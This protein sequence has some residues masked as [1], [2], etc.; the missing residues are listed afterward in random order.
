MFSWCSLNS[1]AALCCEVKHDDKLT[2]EDGV[3][4]QVGSVRVGIEWP[5]RLQC[6]LLKQRSWP[7]ARCNV[8]EGCPSRVMQII[9]IQQPGPLYLYLLYVKLKSSSDLILASQNRTFNLNIKF[10]ND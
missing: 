9:K 5:S 2:D 1:D 3:Y 7:S 8:H 10:S 6:G 4:I